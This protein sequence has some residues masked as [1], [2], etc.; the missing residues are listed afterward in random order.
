MEAEPEPTPEPEVKV[1]FP[2]NV[3]PKCSKALDDHVW[4]S[5]TIPVCKDGK[6]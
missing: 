1:E 6:K 3:C 2:T 4:V 5:D